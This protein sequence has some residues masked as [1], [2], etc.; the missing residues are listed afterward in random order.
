MNPFAHAICWQEMAVFGREVKEVVCRF[1]SCSL[2]LR[3]VMD[4][5]MLR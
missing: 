3:V 4:S 5:K 2:V 1:N